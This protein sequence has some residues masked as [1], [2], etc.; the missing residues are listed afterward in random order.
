LAVD[1][2]AKPVIILAMGSPDHDI[3]VGR[4]GSADV[5]GRP[6]PET[7]PFPGPESWTRDLAGRIKRLRNIKRLSQRQLATRA[8]VNVTYLNKIENG[9]QTGSEEVLRK[10]AHALEVPVTEL[11][12]LTTHV[13]E[14]IKSM[15]NPEVTPAERPTVL[16][17]F[18][19]PIGPPRYTTNFVNRI[20]QVAH[21]KRVWR[22]GAIITVTGP[23]GCGK[24]RL[25]AELI[26]NHVS[27]D[28]DVTWLTLRES[29][30][31]DSVAEAIGRGNAG[32]G[33]VVVLDDADLALVVTSAIA[34]QL[35]QASPGMT[36]LATSRQPLGIYGEQLLPLT[37]LPVPDPLLRPEQTL[38]A[39]PDL[40]RLKSQDSLSLFIDR[41]SLAV[42]GFELDF[43]NAA[44][45]FDVCRGLDGLPLAIELA[46]RRL[47]QMTVVD[48]AA[49]LDDPLAWLEGN[50]TD[51]P[52][53]HSS[54]ETAIRWSFE[55][56]SEDQRGVAA[57]LA[58]FPVPFRRGDA[59]EVAGDGS[60]DAA[61]IRAIVLELVDRSLLVRE[62]DNDGRAMYRFPEPVRLYAQRELA[63]APEAESR[64]RDLYAAWCRRL[65]ESLKDDKPRSEAEWARLAGVTPDLFASVHRLP[66]E[67]QGAALARLSGAR[68]VVLQFGYGDSQKYVR[69]LTQEKDSEGAGRPG[70]LREAGILARVRGEYED[71][72]QYLQTALEIATNQR[73]ALGQANSYLDLAENA[74][75]QGQYDHAREHLERAGALYR[76]LDNRR[77]IVE[78]ENLDGRTR[79]PTA[80]P[81]SAQPLFEHA[82]LLSREM[83]DLRLQ[84]YSLYNLG[85][86]DHRLRRMASARRHLEE[87]LILRLSIR[88]LR[89][90][91]RIVETF[92]LI[93]SDIG[94]HD[95][96]LQLLGAARQYRNVS[97]MQ[98]MPDWWRALLDRVEEEARTALASTSG[99]VAH[100][101]EL[102]AA[103]GL[104]TA[105]ELALQDTAAPLRG[106][107]D[108]RTAAL[109]RRRVPREHSVE[110]PRADGLTPARRPDEPA[111]LDAALV[112]LAKGT[113]SE[114][115]VQ[116]RLRGFEL[117][118]LGEPV[119]TKTDD[120][121]CFTLHS[122]HHRGV[123]LPV[124]TRR[125][126][127]ADVVRRRP[128]WASKPVVKIRYERLRDT[129]IEGETVIINPWLPTEYRFSKT[130]EGYTPGAAQPGGEE[131]SA[132]AEHD[133]VSADPGPQSPGP[134]PPTSTAAPNARSLPTKRS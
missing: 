110:S 99:E 92:C 130:G 1:I 96:A 25:A 129:L 127:V 56:L 29:D 21:F 37:G 111:H 49:E 44:A 22:P 74:Y 8:G 62:A 119:G 61:R 68:T 53:R 77:G 13:P 34:R 24:T 7:A 123:V 120:L 101:L 84:A 35:V 5:D 131:L 126:A 73:D 124:F 12:V 106:A 16:P 114:V 3:D 30:D 20:E 132:Q 113:G 88:N 89:G 2:C 70:V 121:L 26:T 40:N 43:T 39:K 80:D 81:A 50:T 122:A 90:V 17:D 125:S 71:A 18:P 66:N 45:V 52:R 93:E 86:L 58:L 51:V 100:N 97:Q 6:D 28:A 23:P 69:Q 102:G 134:Q 79:M 107:L 46:A 42:P 82:L 128:E 55:R 15:V 133:A 118:A 117:L 57:R 116:R 11:L 115:D 47:G 64:A 87:S 67:E 94:S 36:V 41:A 33:A 112:E 14:E 32:T 78:V 83:E 95:I 76:D 59:A 38:G 91:A 75:D 65:V 19:Q 54:L 104:Q 108:P 85:M 98:G 109:V 105:A 103:M 27:N 63:R 10:L 9:R 72:T 48:L 31:Q 4:P 60:V